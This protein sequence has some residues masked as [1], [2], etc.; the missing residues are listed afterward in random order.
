MALLLNELRTGTESILD[1][2]KTIDAE[3]A[4]NPDGTI[5]YGKFKSLFKI[6]ITSE[7][8]LE[9]RNLKEYTLLTSD[10]I[11]NVYPD[12]KIIVK[13]NQERL[14]IQEFTKVNDET[15]IDK[16]VIIIRII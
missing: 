10:I 7:L 4:Y 13:F 8:D 9:V 6:T 5:T 15:S 14:S 2:I 12:S 3:K 16:L 1:Y 11:Q